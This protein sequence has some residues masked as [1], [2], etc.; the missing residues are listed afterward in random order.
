M[1][2]DEIWLH[3]LKMNGGEE[4]YELM[5]KIKRLFDPEN[6]LNPGCPFKSGPGCVYKEL[7]ANT[8]GE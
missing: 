3:L 1:A 8:V 5:W 2:R 7:K 6:I 4:I